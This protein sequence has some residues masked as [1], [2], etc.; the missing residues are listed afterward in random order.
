MFL[1]NCAMGDRGCISW[2]KHPEL[3]C[4]RRNCWN[5]AVLCIVFDDQLKLKLKHHISK[6][7]VNIKIMP[8]NGVAFTSK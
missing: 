2:M 5:D 7:F 4:F 3:Y 6:K 1:V 8:F